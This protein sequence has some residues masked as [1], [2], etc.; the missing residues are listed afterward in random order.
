VEKEEIKICKEKQL[1]KHL[2]IANKR[3]ITGD[4]ERQLRAIN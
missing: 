1:K 3:G 2:S 4:K